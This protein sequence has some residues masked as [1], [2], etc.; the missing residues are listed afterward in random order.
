MVVSRR[1]SSLLILQSS[2]PS[3]FWNI[4]VSISSKPYSLIAHSSHWRTWSWDHSEGSGEI[5]QCEFSART[6]NEFN[7]KCFMSK[8]QVERVKLSFFQVLSQHHAT[9]FLDFI[10][11]AN[12]VHSSVFDIL[13]SKFRKQPSNSVLVIKWHWAKLLEVYRR[14]T[15]HFI[16]KE[17]F[18]ILPLALNISFYVQ[19]PISLKKKLHFC[20][21]YSVLKNRIIYFFC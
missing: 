20:L 8:S 18:P 7:Q 3:V 9:A 5:R 15:V 21:V 12:K 11:C 6:L 13:Q 10:H 17:N 14:V 19:E 1:K 4:A 2:L 16:H